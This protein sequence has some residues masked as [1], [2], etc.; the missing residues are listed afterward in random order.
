TPPKSHIRNP[1]SIKIGH[2]TD[3][4]R[5]L[6]FIN[7]QDLGKLAPLGTS[8]PDHFL[9]TKIK[10]LVLDLPPDVDLS[11]FKSIKEKIEPQFEEY[12][13]DYAEYYNTCKHPNSPA[14]RDP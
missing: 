3:D 13:N 14:M 12:R 5:V 10:P 2:F 7:S 9:R 6:E 8:C 1:K 11:D 4:N